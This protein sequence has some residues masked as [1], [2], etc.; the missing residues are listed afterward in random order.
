LQEIETIVKRLQPDI[1]HLGTF[2]E[3][4]S[5]ESVK[6]LKSKFYFLKIMRS[7]PVINEESIRL[8][9]DYDQVADF[10]LLDTYKMGDKQI[11]ATGIIHNWKIS[12][13][14]VDAVR[15]P[16]ILA[17]GLSPENV[18]EAIRQV[19]PAGVDS[20]TGTDKDGSHEK[21]LEKIKRFVETIRRV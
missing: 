8:A 13:A 10:L 14:I 15:I 11:G 19:R 3:G 1:L 20:K 5:P 21:D 12:R 2:P 6:S 4:I 16:V 18:A 7:I 17:G 9:I